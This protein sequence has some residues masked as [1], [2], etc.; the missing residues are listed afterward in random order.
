MEKTCTVSAINE[1]SKYEDYGKFF[2][3]HHLRG[4]GVLGLREC[5]Q[6]PEGLK[7]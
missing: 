5:I 4:K 1:K 7:I 6:N 3:L 2:H